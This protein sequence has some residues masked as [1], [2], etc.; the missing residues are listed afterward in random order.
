MKIIISW[1]PAIL[2]M[3]VIFY[4]SSQPTNQVDIS[5]TSRFLFFK[6][7]HLLEY[8]ILFLAY[9]WATKSKKNSF[10]LLLIFAISDEYH[11]IFTATRTPRLTDVGIDFLGGNLGN[12]FYSI[13]PLA[14]KSKLR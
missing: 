8:S 12:L 13:I 11:Q 3:C 5:G 10:I 6:S 9:L 2:W 14:P 7:L 4:F 1:L